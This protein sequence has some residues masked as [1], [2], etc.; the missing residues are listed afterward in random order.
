[1]AATTLPGSVEGLVAAL[2]AIEQVSSH[3]AE[4]SRADRGSEYTRRAANQ[5][6]Y[7]RDW[8]ER[9]N[10]GNDQCPDDKCDDTCGD[11]PALGVQAVNQGA[12]RGL[13]ENACNTADRQC[14]T[15]TL[16]V[17]SARGQVDGE[18]RSDPGLNIREEEVQ[19]IKT[20]Q[21]GSGRGCRSGRACYGRERGRASQ[22]G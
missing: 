13:R 11:K 10:Q 18:K 2:P 3:H 7:G 8:R 9:W 19:P 6:L 4:G 15:Y 14:N 21:S 20:A 12:G 5:D 22:G 16:F 17:P 1:M